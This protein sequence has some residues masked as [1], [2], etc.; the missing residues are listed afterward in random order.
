MPD[1]QAP[2]VPAQQAEAPAD[3]AVQ[4]PEQPLQA[5][6]QPAPA[7]PPPAPKKPVRSAAAKKKLVRRIIAIVVTLA[8][9][10][11][12]VFGM[13]FLVFRED[14]SQGFIYAEPAYIGS[15]QSVV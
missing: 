1:L 8:I 9:L 5:P 13:W 15:I 10:S 12:I 6:E 3:Q 4:A 14:D 2:E 7:S 11:G